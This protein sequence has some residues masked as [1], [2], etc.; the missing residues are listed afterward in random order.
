MWVFFLGWQ[1]DTNHRVA[2]KHSSLTRLL[3]IQASP[4]RNR[5]ERGSECE[6]SNNIKGNEI[7]KKR[8]WQLYKAT[9]TCKLLVLNNP[10]WVAASRWPNQYLVGIPCKYSAYLHWITSQGCLFVHYIMLH[11]LTFSV[12]EN[13][14]KY[15]SSNKWPGLSA[16]N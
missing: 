12:I 2:E 4:R 14:S 5:H 3:R 9:L 10:Y 15:F 11:L 7:W 16:F 13:M 6:A 1:D 8:Y